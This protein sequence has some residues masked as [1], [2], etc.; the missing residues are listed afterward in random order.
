MNIAELD[1]DVEKILARYRVEEGKGFRLKKHDPGDSSW[2]K[3][4]S[5]SLPIFLWSLLAAS[6]WSFSHS[7]RSFGS[8]N[9]IP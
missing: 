7:F 9:E 1:I 8:G 2:K 5:C 6:S 3:N 4:S